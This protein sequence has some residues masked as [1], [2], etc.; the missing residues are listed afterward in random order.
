MK[1]EFELYLE[2]KKKLIEE[3][4]KKYFIRE[5]K[6]T[7]RLY[8]AMYY[9]ISAGGKRLRPI[10]FLTVLDELGETR[11]TKDL[12]PAAC[13]IEMIHTYSLIHD[14]L[15]SMDNDDLRRGKPT[16]HKKYDETT[17]I[18][19]G[20][21]LFA[22]AIETFLK[23]KTEYEYIVSG[24]EKLIKA[25][26]MKGMV[27][28]QFVDTKSDYFKKDIKTL[29]FIH[30][31]KTAAMIQASFTLPSILLGY[32]EQKINLLERLGLH[33]GLLFQIIDDILDMTS[34][35]SVLGKTAGKDQKQ[36]KLTYVNLFDLKQAKEFARKEADR[37][38]KYIKKM[39]FTTGRLE[40]IIDI[41]LTRI[42]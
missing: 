14:D 7:K 11:R 13:S 27:A 19:A 3:N 1:S 17:A 25:S 26:G 29:N 5:D 22:Y 33:A 35:S 34:S 31:K 42:N 41:F 4:L 20:D 21:A 38:L 32:D 36:N 2:K 18:L 16:L 40:K 39:E 12:L 8:E 9:S 23:T 6:F 10:I 28:G 37:A 15:P 30:T 24:L